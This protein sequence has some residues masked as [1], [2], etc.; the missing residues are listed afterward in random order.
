M[1]AEAVLGQRGPSQSAADSPSS[2]RL[3]LAAFLEVLS[4]VKTLPTYF[5]LTSYHG[6]V[7]ALGIIPEELSS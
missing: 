5:T 6:D 2:V 1:N 3:L 4:D 7:A